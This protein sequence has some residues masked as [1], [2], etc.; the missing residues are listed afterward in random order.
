MCFQVCLLLR[1][2]GLPVTE[3]QPQIT[4]VKSRERGLSER[5]VGW[6]DRLQKE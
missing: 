1:T 2:L 6:K 4:L 5:W 3:T